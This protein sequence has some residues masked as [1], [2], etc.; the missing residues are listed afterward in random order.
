MKKSYLYV[1]YMKHLKI[2]YRSGNQNDNDAY[3]D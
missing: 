1:V 2:I 3:T